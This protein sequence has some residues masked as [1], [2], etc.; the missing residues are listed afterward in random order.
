MKLVQ[1]GGF[2][3]LTNLVQSSI[4]TDSTINQQDLNWYLGASYDQ[5][6]ASPSRST[7]T[8]TTEQLDKR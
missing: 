3:R 5:M 1:F 4:S 6:R 8:R 7:K 2:L